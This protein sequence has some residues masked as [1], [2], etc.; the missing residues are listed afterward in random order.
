MHLLHGYVHVCVHAH[1]L[2]GGTVRA[3]VQAELWA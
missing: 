2:A 1:V 3:M